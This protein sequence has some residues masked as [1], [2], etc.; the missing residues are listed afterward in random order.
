MTIPYTVLRLDV[1]YQDL[2][3]ITVP[4]ETEPRTVL[5]LEFVEFTVTLCDGFVS[6]C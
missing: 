6:K 4:C 5:G 1:D 2:R 3:C